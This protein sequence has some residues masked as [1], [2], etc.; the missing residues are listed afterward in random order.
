LG[1]QLGINKMCN[2]IQEI[3]REIAELSSTREYL[4]IQWFEMGE[5]DRNFSLSP[6]YPDNQ[7]Y[8]C[9]YNDRDYQIEIGFQL[10]A[11]SIEQF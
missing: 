6:Q 8:M 11:T 3:N 5:A 9:G 4:I 10:E 1:E 7:W 2:G